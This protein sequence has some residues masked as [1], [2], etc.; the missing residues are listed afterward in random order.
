MNIEEEIHK[1]W[2]VV[3]HMLVLIDYLS[4]VQGK[5]LGIPVDFKELE[6]VTKELA[7]FKAECKANVEG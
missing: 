3:S 2:K 1:I 6:K 4:I 7:E 5:L